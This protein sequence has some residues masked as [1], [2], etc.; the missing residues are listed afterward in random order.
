MGWVGGVDLDHYRRHLCDEVVNILGLLV[1]DRISRVSY[2]LLQA[3]ER[4]F[5]LV[6]CVLKH[7]LGML[8]NEVM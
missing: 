5:K 4:F 3:V 1:R 8:H 7:W 6:S 2:D